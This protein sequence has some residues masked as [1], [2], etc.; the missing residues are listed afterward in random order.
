M[1]LL[2]SFNVGANGYT[3]NE[4]Y[5]ICK[6][7]DMYDRGVCLG[8]ITS[9]YDYALF[10]ELRGK[11][12]IDRNAAWSQAIKIFTAYADKNP[13]DLHYPAVYLIHNSIIDAFKCPNQ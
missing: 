12:C 13:K 1:L 7:K 5:N 2:F 8:Y 9:T 3:G 11:V 6:S 10:T 4:L